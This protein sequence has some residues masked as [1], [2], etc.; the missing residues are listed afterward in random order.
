MAGRPTCLMPVTRT[1]RW[2]HICAWVAAVIAT[3]HAAKQA[4]CL[5]VDSTGFHAW[6]PRSFVQTGVVA[7]EEE[8]P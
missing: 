1:W 4:L 7:E 5:P 3:A 6:M 2:S 8:G